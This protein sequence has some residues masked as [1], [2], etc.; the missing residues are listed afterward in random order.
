MLFLCFVPLDLWGALKP[1]FAQVLGIAVAVLMA[2]V[3]TCRVVVLVLHLG[4]GL[5][6]AHVASEDYDP[7]GL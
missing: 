3:V 7:L 6:C 1:T 2:D 5:G 4:A